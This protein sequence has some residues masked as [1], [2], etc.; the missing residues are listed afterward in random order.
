M[1][2]LNGHIASSTTGRLRVKNPLLKT[3]D[4]Q[5]IKKCL[6]D[7][8]GVIS[9]D[10]NS[11]LGSMLVK[12]DPEKIDEEKFSKVFNKCIVKAQ[13]EESDEKKEDEELLKNLPAEI[14][15]TGKSIYK[16]SRKIENQTMAFAGG[17]CVAAVCTKLWK[18]HAV[19]GWIFAAA[20]TAHTIRYR[21]T[22]FK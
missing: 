6:S 5:S 3:V 14:K 22:V 12:F 13:R 9:I 11:L 7:L 18:L 17:L 8:K 19:A 1:F 4:V 20:A 21:K 2:E 16:K 10:V 15:K